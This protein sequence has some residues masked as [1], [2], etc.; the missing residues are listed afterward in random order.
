MSAGGDRGRRREHGGAAGRA[1]AA[2]WARRN[3]WT[4]GLVGV[5]AVML[6]FTKII[7][8]NYGPAQIQGLAIGVLPVA[9]A[10]IAQAIIVISGGIDLS[11]ASIMAL[12]G[13]TAAVL[14][15]GPGRRRGHPPR[16]RRP[17]AGARGRRRQRVAHRRD[18]GPGHRGH[19]RDVVRLGG[20][21]AARPG[22]AGRRLRVLAP[23]ARQR[24]VPERVGPAGVPAC[25]RSSCSSS[26][27]PCG[28]RCSAC[29]M[30]AL[31]SSRLAAFRSGVPVG[32]TKVAPMRSAGCSARSAG[33]AITASD[34]R[35]VAGPGS[36]HAPERGG[37]RA[38]WREPR[39][40]TR[41][42][43]RADRGGA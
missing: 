38:R 21:D 22:L 32:R 34:R 24:V 2:S 5:L 25:S 27:C 8:P 28:G 13:V 43:R 9:F 36:V 40:R 42:D 6:A 26:G 18:P 35:R 41:R 12:T 11:V 16:P 17:G 39:R 33:L 7:Q 14:L 3:A 23:G 37:D 30:Y 20:N 19:P 29:R 31:G 15:E 4:L 1:S 10:A